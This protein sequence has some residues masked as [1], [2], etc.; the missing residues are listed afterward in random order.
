[1]RHLTYFSSIALLVVAAVY[2]SNPDLEKDGFA[3]R[4]ESTTV[5]KDGIAAP[6]RSWYSLELS[7]ETVSRL[8]QAQ[9]L[10][11]DSA[12]LK[13]AD[14]K[15]WRVVYCKLP[16]GEEF[17]FSKA[18]EWNWVVTR[19]GLTGKMSVGVRQP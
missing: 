2:A 12:K 4:K 6:R 19:D 1:V 8:V 5:G 16:N 7:V 9:K 10:F 13:E 17:S 3:V 11:L 14:L 18:N 15:H